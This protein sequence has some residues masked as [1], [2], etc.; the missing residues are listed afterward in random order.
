[1]N[2]HIR[3][4][5][6][7]EQHGLGRSILLHLVPGGLITAFYALTARPIIKAGYPAIVA[8]MLGILFILIPV[9]LGYLLYQGRKRNGLVSLEGIVLYRETLPVWQYVVLVTGLLAWAGL[10]FAYATPV[11]NF[12]IDNFFAW[13]PEWYFFADFTEGLS[14][15]SNSTI[16]VTIGL[17]L[18]LNGIAGPIVEELYFRGYLLP[19]ISRYGWWAPVLNAVL[20]S[21]YHFFSP[22]Q[23]LIRILALL[24]MTI[25]T[26]WKRNIYI[27]MW[28]HVLLNTIG[29][30]LA[31]G[32]LLSGV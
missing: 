14:Q 22:W 15:Y 17:T 18:V 10:L 28:Q 7:I 20:F 12:F 6:T 4:G 29:V 21:I 1:M 25:V 5:N 31:I 2:E 24:P 32:L 26:Q 19:R 9:E 3:T 27:G 11:D 8:L 16:I 23:N 30:L 13:I